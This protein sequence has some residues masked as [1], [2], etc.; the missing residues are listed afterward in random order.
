[1]PAPNSSKV[2]KYREADYRIR[3]P[4]AL[5]VLGIKDGKYDVK[6]EEGWVITN[7][8]LNNDEKTMNEEKNVMT[9]IG[10]CSDGD[11]IDTDNGILCWPSEDGESRLFD[12]GDEVVITIRKK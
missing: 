9:L 10:K 12:D 6:E 1:M 4:K 5:Q 8:K 2:T 11:Y 3:I 7:C